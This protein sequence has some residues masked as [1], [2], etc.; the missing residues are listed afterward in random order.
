MKKNL[1]LIVYFIIFFMLLFGFQIR[2]INTRYLATALLF[3]E[4]VLIPSYRKQIGLLFKS[5]FKEVTKCVILFNVV[6][7]L[8]T[9]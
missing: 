6:T 2:G 3:I 4:C 8:I 7:F 5:P 9:F 1:Q